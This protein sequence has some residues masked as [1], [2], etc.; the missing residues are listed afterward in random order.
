M[1]SLDRRGGAASIDV[2]GGSTRP[3]SRSIGKGD[4]IERVVPVIRQLAAAG[5]AVSIDTRKADVMTPA[6][7]AGARM[8]NDVS[9]RTYDPRSSEVAASLDV[10]IV[11]MH[12]QGAPEVMQDDPRY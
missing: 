9:A 2:G 10:P 8:I 3:G 1:G 12:H 5:T 11:L 7:E 4:E 6:V